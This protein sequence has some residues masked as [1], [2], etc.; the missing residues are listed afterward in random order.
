LLT[1]IPIVA[2]FVNEPDVPVAVNVYVPG[3]VVG[4]VSCLVT[5]THAD[6]PTDTSN[7]STPNESA[8]GRNVRPFG[9]FN[10]STAIASISNAAN[11]VPQR[12]ATGGNF[13]GGTFGRML[14]AVPPVESVNVDVTAVVPL[15][16]TDVGLTVHVDSAGAPEQE[17]A[18]VPVNPPCG[19]TVR[20]KFSLN[21]E[22]T[23]LP[24]VKAIE[25]SSPVP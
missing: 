13:V 7:S 4:M 21:P 15:S 25:K 14:A 22:A 8:A 20:V 6:M 3:A 9:A 1:V 2:V 23:V 24:P 11:N 17:R 5:P 16:V 10:P 12:T 18:T 19:V